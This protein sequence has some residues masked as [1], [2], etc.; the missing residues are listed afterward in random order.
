MSDRPPLPTNQACNV[1]RETQLCG[2]APAVRIFCVNST[3]IAPKRLISV[4]V[5]GAQ[6]FVCL[7]EVAF[8]AALVLPQH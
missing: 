8:V 7:L 5:P 1:S 4:L 2:L 3:Y 6:R